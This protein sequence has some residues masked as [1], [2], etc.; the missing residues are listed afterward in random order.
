MRFIIIFF[1][2]SSVLYANCTQKQMQTAQ[3]LYNEARFEE[4]LNVCYSAEIEANALMVKAEEALDIEK[5]IAYY[6]EASIAISKFSDQEVLVA[7]QKRL[8]KIL[9]KLYAPINQ[10]ISET[11]SE[12]VRKISSEKKEE[13]STF[14][15]IIYTLFLLIIL[16]SFQPLFKKLGKKQS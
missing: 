10:E 4:A 12:K 8:Q 1:F 9:S 11:Y 6:K 7:E 15:Y 5:K 2:T 14:K 13:S 3:S 16:W